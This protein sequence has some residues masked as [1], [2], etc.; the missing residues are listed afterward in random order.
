MSVLAVPAQSAPSDV[1]GRIVNFA[2]SLLR[3]GRVAN[4]WEK[5]KV[6]GMI[7]IYQGARRRGGL[8]HEE[9]REIAGTVA[10]KGRVKRLF[11]DLIDRARAMAN[12][13]SI[14]HR[15]GRRDPNQGRRAICAI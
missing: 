1:V 11:D 2:H 10:Q 8:G 12:H 5:Q 6:H 14:G 13:P 3:K 4:K 7:G 15:R 9:A